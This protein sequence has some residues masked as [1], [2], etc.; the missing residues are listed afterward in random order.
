MPR[1]MRN[2]SI[3][4]LLRMRMKVSVKKGRVR[5][6]REF[7][8]WHSHD[9]FQQPITAKFRNGCIILHIWT[10]L[11]WRRDSRGDTQPI[12]C[13]HCLAAAGRSVQQ[14]CA[15]A[16]EPCRGEGLLEVAR[17]VGIAR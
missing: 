8:E 14:R 11:R 16:A 5:P 10:P 9:N 6:A 12:A 13:G 4:R 7:F 3:S 15:E 1:L 17:A 2:Y